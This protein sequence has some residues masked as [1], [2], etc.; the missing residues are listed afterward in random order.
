VRKA[1]VQDAL[2]GGEGGSEDCEGPASPAH[3]VSMLMCCTCPCSRKE[4]KTTLH[5]LM[6]VM[7]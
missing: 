2:Q 7:P 1:L 6:V 5:M 4:V 3:G